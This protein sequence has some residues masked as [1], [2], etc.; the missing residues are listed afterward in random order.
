VDRQPA[1]A[2]FIAGVVAAPPTPLT[3]EQ[4]GRLAVVL[5]TV[6]HAFD[7]VAP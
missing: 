7:G 3:D 2:G 5:A 4:A 6:V 1:L